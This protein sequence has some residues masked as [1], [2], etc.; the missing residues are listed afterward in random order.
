MKQLFLGDR[1]VKVKSKHFYHHHIIYLSDTLFFKR[2]NFIA[3]KDTLLKE[4][5]FYTK[6]ENNMTARIKTDSSFNVMKYTVDLPPF[7]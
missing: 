4:Y 2:N 5:Y 6:T 1:I 3:F 7:Y